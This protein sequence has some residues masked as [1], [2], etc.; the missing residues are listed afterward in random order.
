MVVAAIV[1]AAGLVPTAA[2][3]SAGKDVA[4]ANKETLV[5]AGRLIMEMV[6]EYG[7]SLYPS[8]ASIAPFFSHWRDT[9]ER[10]SNA[11]S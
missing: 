9:G 3:I 6:E 5:T 1:G 8:T 2:A 7:C 10:M 4:L 11:S